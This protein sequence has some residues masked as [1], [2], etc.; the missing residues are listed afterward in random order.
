MKKKNELENR[1]PKPLWKNLEWNLGAIMFL[2][3]QNTTWQWNILWTELVIGNE[4]KEDH[5]YRIC[6]QEAKELNKTKHNQIQKFKLIYYYL[7]INKTIKQCHQILSVELVPHA[8]TTV[9]EYLKLSK[10]LV[11]ADSN[12]NTENIFMQIVLDLW[13]EKLIWFVQI[14]YNWYYC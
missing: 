7:L 11:C 14:G 13:I 6:Y 3:H 4:E 1:K 8:Q 2:L 5:Y 9:C 12:V 10:S